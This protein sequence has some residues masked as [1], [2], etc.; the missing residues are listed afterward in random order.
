MFPIHPGLRRFMIVASGACALTFLRSLP[1]EAASSV[2]P[3][4]ASRT[5]KKSTRLRELQKERLAVL[6]EIAAQMTASYQAGIA[7]FERLQKSSRAVL[8]AELALCESSAERIAVAEKIVAL[9]REA[10]K[11]V[12]ARHEVG[13][14]TSDEVL[15]A[16][17]ARLEA[18][19]T[20]ERLKAQAP[21]RPR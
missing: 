9:E 17:A 3:T 8:D 10:E 5:S 13:A 12:K 15:T 14:G 21:T 7:P 19:I 11:N 20:L 1:V 18:E 6:R 16:R 4:N 2:R